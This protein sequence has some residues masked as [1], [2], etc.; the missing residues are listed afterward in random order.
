MFEKGFVSMAYGDVGGPNL[1]FSNMGCFGFCPQEFTFLDWLLLFTILF[2]IVI[3]RYSFAANK[4]RRALLARTAIP[5]RADWH[6]S[7]HVLPVHTREVPKGR[8]RLY[9]GDA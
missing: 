4:A 6:G 7:P 2:T 8:A 9:R 1:D 3:I 5:E